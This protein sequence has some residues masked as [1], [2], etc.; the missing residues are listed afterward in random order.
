MINFLNNHTKEELEAMQIKSRI[1]TILT[2]K[3]VLTLR[4]FLQTLE[5]KHHEMKVDIGNFNL[6]LAAL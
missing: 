2:V 5:R 6:K 1:D 4:S 3:K